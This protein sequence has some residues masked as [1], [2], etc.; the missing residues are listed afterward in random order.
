ML[1]RLVVA[2]AIFTDHLEATGGLM[3]VGL[4]AP[5]TDA[6]NTPAKMKALVGTLEENT[7]L[8]D[9]YGFRGAALEDLRTL[10]EELDAAGFNRKY[11]IAQE[12]VTAKLHLKAHFYATPEAWDGLM[13]GPEAE[14]FLEAYY[15]GIA[16]QNQALSEGTAEAGDME[17]TTEALIPPGVAMIEAHQTALDPALRERAMLYLTV[18]SHNQNFRSFI[19]DGEV[20]FVVSGWAALHGLPDFITL[21]GLSIW[22][23]DLEDLEALFPRYEGMQRRLGRWMRIVV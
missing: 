23:N 20:A 8:R 13:G 1:G 11:A 2:Q 22:V 10:A 18:G 12:V 4:Y 5:E 3:K 6:G 17:A 16:K 7:W 9:L 19:M 14:T 15:R 21:A